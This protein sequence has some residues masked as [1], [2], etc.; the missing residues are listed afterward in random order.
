MITLIS[1][2]LK[3]RSRVYTKNVKYKIVSVRLFL[4]YCNCIVRDKLNLEMFI[5][6]MYSSNS[7]L[8]TLIT[9]RITN[10]KVRD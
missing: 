4:M 8:I 2:M 1:V 6:T 7:K 10:E 3:I 5:E 9:N